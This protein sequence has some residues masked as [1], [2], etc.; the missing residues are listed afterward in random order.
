MIVDL[1][2]VLEGPRYFN[3]TLDN[4][5]WE[6]EREDDQIQGLDGPLD[7]S[8]SISR[9]GVRYLLDGRLRGRLCLRCDRCLGPYLHD[10]RSDFRLFFAQG[11]A[12]SSGPSEVELMEQD[13]ST[14]F[15]TEERVDLDEIIREQIYLSLPMKSLC[16]E[17]CLGLCPLCGIDLNNEKCRCRPEK[18]SPYF[19]KLKD[20]KLKG[21]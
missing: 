2:S 19:S 14:D 9:A 21:E 11:P 15:V 6:G 13:L 20:L 10:L 16:R 7:V 12:S 18:G 4:D 5:W 17:D 8:L 1:R 3:L